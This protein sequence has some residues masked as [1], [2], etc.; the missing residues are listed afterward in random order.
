MT[1][2]IAAVS[3]FFCANCITNFAS[4]FNNFI[5]TIEFWF[6]IKKIV[7]TWFNDENVPT[8]NFFFSKMYF[9]EWE[10]NFVINFLFPFFWS[11]ETLFFLTLGVLQRLFN[12]SFIDCK[13]SFNKKK[14]NLFVWF[15]SKFLSYLVLKKLFPKSLTLKRTYFFTLKFFNY[16]KNSIRRKVAFNAFISLISRVHP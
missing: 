5:F 10:I 3:E 7:N 16:R 2:K 9:D 15:F 14:L 4:K 13:V 11:S 12:S 1:C 8:L 6:R